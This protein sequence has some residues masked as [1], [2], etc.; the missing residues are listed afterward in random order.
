M[1]RLPV[2]QP[3]GALSPAGNGYCI[4]RPPVGGVWT[5]LQIES[6]EQR[7]AA[8]NML[9][10]RGRAV[11]SVIREEI[12]I[13]DLLCKGVEITDPTSGEVTQCTLLLLVPPEG[14]PVQSVS[15]V[16]LGTLEAL[17]SLGI[18][19]PYVPA[20]R[21]RIHQDRVQGGKRIMH[22]LEILG[23]AQE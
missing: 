8:V 9:S 11:D 13:R 3:V 19:P 4:P 1:S 5:S 15:S 20:L 6:E 7:I 22:R 16:V 23:R 2:T 18:R 14:E 21:C 17:A 10:Q 12:L